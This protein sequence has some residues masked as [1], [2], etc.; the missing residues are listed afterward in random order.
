EVGQQCA[1]A[2][3]VE[4]LGVWQPAGGCE[5][6]DQAQPG[7]ASGGKCIRIVTVATD[8]IH[9]QGKVEWNKGRVTK[10]HGTSL[11][12]CARHCGLL[13]VR[14]A[15]RLTSGQ[16]GIVVQGKVWSASVPSSTL[17]REITS[18]AA[19]CNRKGMWIC[20]MST[21][22]RCRH[23]RGRPRRIHVSV[24]SLDSAVVTGIATTECLLEAMPN[25]TVP[26]ARWSI[27]MVITSIVPAA[28]R[29]DRFCASSVRS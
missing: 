18:P 1:E 27:F 12:D 13:V 5:C 26:E 16:F 22:A 10:S 21:P 11:H 24:G 9:G 17:V 23:C 20:R 8:G 14:A 15:C 19:A 7:Q 25:E 4:R 6:R 28:V 29:L 2:G 3:L